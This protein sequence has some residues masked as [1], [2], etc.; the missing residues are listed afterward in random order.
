MKEKGWMIGCPA[1][2]L[3]PSVTQ[4]CL[5]P[6]A[7]PHLFLAFPCFYSTSQLGGPLLP[8]VAPHS[9]EYDSQTCFSWM[10]TLL[11][12]LLIFTESWNQFDGAQICRNVQIDI[13]GSQMTGFDKKLY[14][15]RYL[16]EGK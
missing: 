14:C 10:A 4:T 1:A 3:L 2:P 8:F 12:A 15:T 7:A 5:S 6:L 16:K 9:L 13:K 11:R